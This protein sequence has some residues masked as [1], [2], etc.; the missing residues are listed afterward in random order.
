[1]STLLNGY[2]ESYKNIFQIQH[3]FQAYQVL[4]R[5]L[6]LDIELNGTQLTR[7]NSDLFNKGH[8]IEIEKKEKR[9]RLMLCH[10][11]VA[12]LMILYQW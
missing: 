4:S 6:Y 3:R 12:L 1:M 11:T 7:V 5:F 10:T 8:I 2:A 9:K